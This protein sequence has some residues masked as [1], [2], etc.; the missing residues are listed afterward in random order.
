M[1]SHLNSKIVFRIALAS[2]E[3]FRAMNEQ[4]NFFPAKMAGKL[5]Y[6]KAHWPT[7]GDYVVGVAQPGGWVLIEEVQERTSVLSRKDPGSGRPQILAVNVDI[8]FVVT[9]ANQDLNLNRLDRYVAMAI[10]RKSTRL[11]SSH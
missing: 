6:Q 11:N 7:V 3:S 9:S 8:L 10:D 2:R 5:R 1:E 4:H